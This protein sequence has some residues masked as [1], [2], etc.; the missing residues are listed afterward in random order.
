MLRTVVMAV[1][2]MTAIAA[3]MSPSAAVSGPCTAAAS[4]CAE[5]IALG[6]GRAR[7]RFYRSHPLDLRNDRIKRALVVVHDID[8][9][10]Q[11]YFTTAIVS[12]R[13]AAALDDTLVIAPRF[14]SRDGLSC[15]DV[16]DA[17]EVNWPCDGNSWRSGAAARGN[18]RTSFDFADEILRKLAR[19]RVFPNLAAIVVTGHSAG[20][21]FVTRYQMANRVHEKLGVPVS[22]V[23]AN[24]SSYAYP[25]A[26]RPAIANGRLEYQLPS[27]RLCGSYD[28]W[29]YGMSDRSGYA[30][31]TSLDVLKKQLV[32]RSATYLLGDR[33][34][35]PVDGFDSSCAAMAQG[36][37]R[38]ERGR[39][40][41]AYVNGR[42]GGKHTVTIVP[43]CGHDA[44]CMFTAAAALPVLFP[45]P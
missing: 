36:A 39:A 29:P 8:R 27:G 43:R 34:V 37:T 31:A 21:Q 32:R 16:L 1:I 13:L 11:E 6:P 9:D 26:V 24:P 4:E 23:V 45:H 40:F 38:L 42:L 20:G 18:P 10:A 12:A 2:T 25:D 41:A 3:P 19:K 15:A 7:A 17:D 33:D 44:K 35:L 14:A 28:Q 5:W 22:Y 30:A